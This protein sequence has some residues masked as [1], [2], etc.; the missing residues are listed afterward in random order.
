MFQERGIIPDRSPYNWPSARAMETLAVQL[1]ECR[2]MAMSDKSRRD[3]AK[4]RIMFANAVATIRGLAPWVRKQTSEP[5]EQY[6]KLNNEPVQ[7]LVE[8]AEEKLA[9]LDRLVAAVL[10]RNLPIDPSHPLLPEGDAPANH[11]QWHD[12]AATLERWF[13]EA[14]QPTNK[15]KAFGRG[16]DGPAMRFLE[17]AIPEITGEHPERGAIRQHLNQLDRDHMKK[18]GGGSTG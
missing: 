2:N 4:K 18:F 7:V 1:E 9:A 17:A 8:Q 15:R 12:L 10:S 5:L 13:N 14:L 6:R 3:D 16:P 11:R